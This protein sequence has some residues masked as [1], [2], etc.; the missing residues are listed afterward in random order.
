MTWRVTRPSRP[1]GC[2]IGRAWFEIADHEGAIEARLRSDDDPVVE[3]MVGVLRATQRFAPGRVA[4]LVDPVRWVQRAVEPPPRLALVQWSDL[5][6]DRQYF[7]FV[8][9]LIDAG[10]LDEREGRSR[11]MPTS[12]TLASGSRRG[13][14]GPLSTSST[15]CVGAWPSL[16]F[17]ASS[18]RSIGLKARSPTRH[19][20]TSSSSRRPKARHRSTSAAAAV[21]PASHRDNCEGERR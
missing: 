19:T 16:N 3:R 13:Q 4:D 5:A 17:V 1:G 20:T 11:Q 21:L 6:T 18:I 10:V 8:L 2:C 15:T 7:E 12:G 9:Q 14:S